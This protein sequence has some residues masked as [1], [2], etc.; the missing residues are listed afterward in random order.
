[1]VNVISEI[2]C[3][4]CLLCESG[5]YEVENDRFANIWYGFLN[6]LQMEMSNFIPHQLLA[7]IQ[8]KRDLIR[9]GN[10]YKAY[11]SGC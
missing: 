7:G 6:K 10:V 4:G 1:M 2:S 5:H 11:I 9:L 8:C 3:L